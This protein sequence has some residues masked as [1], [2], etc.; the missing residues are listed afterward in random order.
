[1]CTPVTHPIHFDLFIL[2]GDAPLPWRLTKES[3]K[4]IEERIKNIIYPHGIDG[5]SNDDGSFINGF[6][7]WRAADRILA[8]FVILPTVLRDYIPELRAGIRKFV[9][10]LRILQGRCING[11]EAYEF[12]VT[13]A[14]TPLTP[15]DIDKAE[16]LIIEGL[17]MIDGK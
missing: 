3:I 7:S 14:S 9:L 2:A 8:L 16:T 17:S 6:R 15:T 12:G 11:K 5:C 13:A 10:G 1:M 4:R